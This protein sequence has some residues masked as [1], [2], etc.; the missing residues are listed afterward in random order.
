[1]QWRQRPKDAGIADQDVEL[2]PAL[3]QGGAERIELV[4]VAKIELEQ[5]RRA[6][7]FPHLVVDLL[8]RTLGAGEQ[9]DVCA[10]A[11]KSEGHGTPDS[12][13]GAC[14]QGNAA[15]KT[16]GH[17]LG[18]SPV[19]RSK[20]CRTCITRLSTWAVPEAHRAPAHRRKVARPP[21]SFP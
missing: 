17:L 8:E 2:A 3:V 14:D 10:L 1:P 15:F 20:G 6:A 12:S 19:A 4:A 16:F 9:H 18:C 13:R 7:D 11:G 5:R 21:A